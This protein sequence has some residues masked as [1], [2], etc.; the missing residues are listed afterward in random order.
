MG[1]QIL[2]EEQATLGQKREAWS[3]ITGTIGNPGE[4][5]WFQLSGISFP[6]GTGKA[7]REAQGHLLALSSGDIEKR[8]EAREALQKMGPNA[9]Q[10]LI[11]AVDSS[12]ADLR[13]HAREIVRS[14]LSS[15][16][17]GPR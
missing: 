10:V 2:D 4:E 3:T 16:R 17:P 12:D 11:S 15:W 9:L 7:F 13:T 5:P 6:E 8:F 14:I 1:F